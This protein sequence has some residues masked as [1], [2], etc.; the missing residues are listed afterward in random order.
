MHSGCD[1]ESMELP[2]VDFSTADRFSSSVKLNIGL[3]NFVTVATT[4]ETTEQSSFV[5]C[6]DGSLLDS[7]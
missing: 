1:S 4:I 5:F 3:E 6:S 7:L 2:T